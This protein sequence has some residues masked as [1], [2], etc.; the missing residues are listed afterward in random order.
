MA[1]FGGFSLSDLLGLVSYNDPLGQSLGLVEL[2]GTLAAVRASS[3]MILMTV[4]LKVPLDS[5]SYFRCFCK[6]WS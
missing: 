6:G 4:L 3:P 5:L 1:I 2:G